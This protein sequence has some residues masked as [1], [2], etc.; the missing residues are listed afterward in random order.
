MRHFALAPRLFLLPLLF[1]LSCDD[2][3]RGGEPQELVIG[4]AAS[5]G[6]L[7]EALARE[8]ERREPAW[9]ITITTAGSNVLARQAS[10]GLPFDLIAL[11]STSLMEDLVARGVVRTGSVTRFAGNRLV[12]IQPENREPFWIDSLDQLLD[13]RIAS[14]AIASPGVPAGEYAR[15]ALR[16][17]GLL[18]RLSPRFIY[19]ANVRAVLAWVERGE[20][21]CGFVYETDLATAE[22]AR[23]LTVESSLHTP[24]TYAIGV[25]AEGEEFMEFLESSMAKEIIRSY[26]FR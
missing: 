26:R 2:S 5:L 20:A 8:F 18:D 15:E 16:A 12:L 24:I 3:T 6:P 4:V 22:V 19:G 7:F 17:S 11:A 13:P 9:E 1:L 14:I 10:A 25:I 23:S 21:T